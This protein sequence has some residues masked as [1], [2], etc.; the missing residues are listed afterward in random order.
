MLLEFKMWNGFYLEEKN[1]E[2]Q[3]KD[4]CLEVLDYD[5]KTHVLTGQGTD[6]HG[7][8][9]INGCVLSNKKVKFTW[10]SL[11]GDIK[12]FFGKLNVSSTEIHGKWGNKLGQPKGSFCLKS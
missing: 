1:E 6:E 7:Q 8:F 10:K 2:N 11:S 3:T 12:Y 5:S 9:S 4:I